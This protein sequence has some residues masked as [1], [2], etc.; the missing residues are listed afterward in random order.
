MTTPIAKTELQKSNQF[1]GYVPLPEREREAI[2]A[3]MPPPHLQKLQGVIHM[4]GWLEGRIANGEKIVAEILAKTDS[5][6]PDY[7]EKSRVLARLRSELDEARYMSHVLWKEYSGQVVYAL[8]KGLPLPIG[9]YSFLES[10]KRIVS[11]EEPEN[12]G[13]FHKT[14]A[15]TPFPL[16]AD[17][18]HVYFPITWYEFANI[19]GPALLIVSEEK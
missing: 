5:D 9:E 18:T 8:P 13:E 7:Q 19:L 1:S 2:L 3:A 14:E 16:A 11:I 12:A 4:I 17:E 6:N 15:Y 10:D